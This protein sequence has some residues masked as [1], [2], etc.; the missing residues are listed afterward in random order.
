MTK[1]QGAPLFGLRDALLLVAA[2]ALG[3]AITRSL[4]N[5]GSISRFDIVASFDRGS[6]YDE[7]IRAGVNFAY[8]QA[9]TPPSR[10]APYAGYFIQRAVFWPTPCVAALT[11]SVLV[12]ASIAPR[13]QQYQRLRRPGIVAALASVAAFCVAATLSPQTLIGLP[14]ASS[15]ALHWKEWWA[16]TW[17]TVPCIAGFAVAM[18]WLS[19]FVGGHWAADRGWLDR[20]GRLLGSCWM[21]QGFLSVLAAWLAML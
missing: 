5:F 2:A 11:L 19:L 15:Q 9:S 10:W 20:L 6:S 21:A 8:S 12:M 18:S 7:H 14:P 16:L 13:D 4:S 3:F 1:T 17:F